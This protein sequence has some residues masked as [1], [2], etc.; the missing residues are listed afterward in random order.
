MLVQFSAHSHSKPTLLRIADG[1]KSAVEDCV[2]QYGKLIWALAKTFSSTTVDAEA[3]VL[4]IFN[5]I[6]EHA[7]R[8]DASKIKESEF[9][10]QIAQRRLIKRKYKVVTS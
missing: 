6:W 7:A 3:A 9:I 8:F 10:V 5:D 2:N 4:E 1:E